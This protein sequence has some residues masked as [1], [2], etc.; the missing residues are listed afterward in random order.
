MDEMEKFSLHSANGI[1][2]KKTIIDKLITF[3]V[4]MAFHRITQKLSGH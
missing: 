1:I 3:F 4:L 2:V